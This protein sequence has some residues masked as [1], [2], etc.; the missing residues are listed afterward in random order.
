MVPQQGP[1][2][3]PRRPPL[4]VD[5]SPSWLRPAPPPAVPADVRGAPRRTLGGGADA[6]GSAAAAR[7]AAGTRGTQLPLRPPATGAAVTWA[8]G[9]GAR[10]V[11]PGGEVPAPRAPALRTAARRSGGPGRVPRTMQ[12]PMPA[13]DGPRARDRDTRRHGPLGAVGRHH[14]AQHWPIW[15]TT[16][17]WGQGRG[18]LAV[19]A[20][21]APGG[22]GRA[23]GDS[24]IAVLGLFPGS[25][26]GC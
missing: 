14:L 10:T 25:R 9:C 4:A 7:A 12:S 18:S 22:Q 21:N 17:C 20:G 19:E 3:P 15:K 23:K 2:R 8:E 16:E 1:R 5:S 26:G 11:R 13:G 6:S 24:L